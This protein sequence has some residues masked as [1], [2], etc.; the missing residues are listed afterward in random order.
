MIQRDTIF[1]ENKKYY[2]VYATVSPKPFNG[3]CHQIPDGYKKAR[4]EKF[5]KFH[6][7]KL[8]WYDAKNKCEEELSHLA[9]P[10]TDQD[11]EIM[12]QFVNEEKDNWVG[13]TDNKIEGNFLD[14][15]GKIF[16]HF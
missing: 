1:K 6:E 4:N 11:L 5:Y 2:R 9:I 15:F 8:T 3:S 12:L 7:N 14:I 10:E 16:F 13:I